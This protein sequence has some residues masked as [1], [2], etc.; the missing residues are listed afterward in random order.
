MCAGKRSGN[1]APK[2]MREYFANTMVEIRLGGGGGGVKKKVGGG[3]GGMLI[4]IC[5]VWD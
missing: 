4:P 1:D 3:G 2:R 5:C